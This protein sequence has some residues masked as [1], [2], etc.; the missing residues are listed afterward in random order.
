MS[1][2]PINLST[3]LFCSTTLFR[4]DKKNMVIF[5]IV[6]NF[7]CVNIIKETISFCFHETKRIT[8]FSHVA[9]HKQS[10]KLNQLVI[11]TILHCPIHSAIVDHNG[12]CAGT[13]RPDRPGEQQQKI[14]RLRL[15]GRGEIQSYIRFLLFFPLHRQPLSFV[16]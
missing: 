3:T 8:A 7:Y 10:T 5:F 11:I 4:S 13:L 14:A 9:I 6:C 1:K 16:A 15:L 12:V 2:I